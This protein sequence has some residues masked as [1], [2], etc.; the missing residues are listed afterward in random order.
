MHLDLSF[1]SKTSAIL[2]SLFNFSI[3]LHSLFILC[4]ILAVA[5]QNPSK[6]DLTLLA[7]VLGTQFYL[8]LRRCSKIN[9]W[10]LKA[11]STPQGHLLDKRTY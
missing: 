8:V 2:I 5:V 1:N 10:S 3:Q 9:R 4:V 11:K 6:I 7:L